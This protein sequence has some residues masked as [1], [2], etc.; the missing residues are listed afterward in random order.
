[1][2]DLLLQ[3]EAEAITLAEL[4]F[5]EL[6][7]LLLDAR[8]E[9]VRLR[10]G[11]WLSIESAPRDGSMFLC[12]V[13]AINYAQEGDGSV[14]DVDVSA[15]DFCEWRDMGDGDGFWMPYTSPHGMGELI[16]NWM[17]ITPPKAA[18]ELG[19]DAK[20]G[21]NLPP[22]LGSGGAGEVGGG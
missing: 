20:G 21:G 13:S 11:G 8:D 12:W 6:S 4:R 16:T 3:L 1:M 17:P 2:T 19:D 5:P 22:P 14:C 15:M 7:K 10:G 9:I 18:P